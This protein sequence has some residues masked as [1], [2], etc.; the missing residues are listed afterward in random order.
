MRRVHSIAASPR[1][2]VQGP[3][4]F[5]LIEILVVVAIIALLLAALAPSL[6]YTKELTRAAVCRSQFH[7]V[8][9]AFGNFASA[10]QGTLPG[11][12]GPPWTGPEDWQGSWMGREVFTEFYQPTPVAATGTLVNYLG[13]EEAARKIYRCPALPQT[14][15]RDGRGSNGMFD[16]TMIQ[17]L[18]GAKQALLRPTATVLHPETA[19]PI[20]T[21]MPLV[22]EEDPTY[23]INSVFVDF[24][25]TSI[26]RMGTWHPN[27][28]GCYIA[29]DGSAHLLSFN[30]SP[31]PQC[32]SWAAVAPSGQLRT[33]G[34]YYTNPNLPWTY[35]CFG[36]WNSQ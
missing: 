1:G 24:G 17:A 13:T 16:Y 15:F 31:G 27:G 19:E 18:P 36:G 8:G 25:H 7:Q 33:L 29:A 12:W 2:P 10:H 26:N 32:S 9:T 6:R 3:S 20:A 21:P 5:T 14:A 4:G 34:T 35:R 23:H 22:L 28:S 11:L 30:T